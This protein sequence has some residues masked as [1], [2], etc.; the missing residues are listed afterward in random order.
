MLTLRSAKEYLFPIRGSILRHP[1]ANITVIVTGGVFAPSA[2]EIGDRFLRDGHAIRILATKSALLFLWAHMLRHPQLI[3]R[4]VS[5]FRPQS[6]ETLAY[7]FHRSIGVPH[8]AEGNWADV[9]VVVPASCNSVGKLVSGINDNYPLLVT[10]AIPRTKRVIVVPSMNPE[11]W[12]DPHLQRNVDLLNL[13]DK[14]E[15]ICPSR[16]LLASGATG[17]G[18]QAPTDMIIGATY[19]AIGFNKAIDS[20]LLDAGSTVP[21]ATTETESQPA[22]DAHVVV[23]D[24]DRKIR[25]EICT[26]LNRV[27][28]DCAVHQFEA[29]RDALGWLQDHQTEVLFTELGS[30]SGVTGFDL[31]DICQ[32][33]GPNRTAIIATSSKD[34]HQIGAERLARQDIQ[35]LPKPLNVQFAVGM[36]VSLLNGVRS[37]TQVTTRNLDEGDLLFQEGDPGTE[38]YLVASG[39]LKISKIRNGCATTIRVIGPGEIVGE[40]AFLDRSTRSATV[41]AAEPCSLVA[42][43]PDEFQAYLDRQ[44]RWIRRMIETLLERLRDTTGRLAKAERAQTGARDGPP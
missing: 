16:G 30:D 24:G 18:I 32:R 33:S 13:T 2:L 6:R 23:V 34:R 37:Q 4:F 11:M 35:F 43:N 20:L 38:A 36:I 28:P 39:S 27:K 12:F 1:M 17:F 22:D 3:P 41:T 40:M 15:V 7:F 14:Y 26:L 42:I 29:P 21:W 19:R 44:P 9:A 31:I 25:A 10:R 5:H 8:I